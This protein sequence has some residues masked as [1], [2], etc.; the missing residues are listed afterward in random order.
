MAD[1]FPPLALHRCRFVDASPSPITAL[2]FPPFSLPSLKSKPSG[3]QPAPNRERALI[4]GTL[5]VGHANGN[6]DLFEWTGELGELQASQAWHRRKTLPG[7]YPSKVDSLTL[8]V[9]HPDTLP[10]DAVP[11]SSDLRLFSSGGGS[12]LLEWDMGR[13]SVR[14]T[15]SSQ[16][17][18][19]WSMAVN[20]ASTLLALGCEDGCVRLLSLLADTLQHFRRFDHVK[21]RILSI[22]WGPPVPQQSKPKV[23]SVRQPEESGDDSENEEDGWTDSWLVTG[24]SD[25]SLRKWD[26]STGRPTDRM[27][28]DKVKGDRTLVWT[29]GVLADGTVISGDSLGTVKFWD[30]LTCTQ[31]HSFPAHGA[32]VLCLTIGLDGT[33]V[34]TSGVDQKI[35]QFTHV[36]STPVSSSSTLATA[37]SRW[38]QSASRRMHSHDIRSLAIWPPYSPLPPA[39][40]RKPGSG[41]SVIAPILISGGLDMSVVITPCLPASVT[42]SAAAARVVNPLAK[43]AATTFEDSYYRRIPYFSA[44]SIARSARL[45]L[46]MHETG[47]NIW[48]VLEIPSTMVVIDGMNNSTDPELRVS[49]ESLLE[50]ELN[51]QTNLIASSLSDDGQ[52]LVVSDLHETKLF[53]LSKT[54]TGEIKPRRVRSL[55]AML[56][57]HICTKGCRSTGGSYF[58]FTPD[59]SKMIMASA[60]TSFILIIDLGTEEPTVL[61]RFDQHREL[62]SLHGGRLLRGSSRN[63]VRHA[64]D[65]DNELSPPDSPPSVIRMAISPDGQWLATSDELCR[66][67]VFNLDSIQYHTTLPSLPHPPNVLTFTPEKPQ[68]LMMVLPNNTIHIFDVERSEVPEWAHD[69]NS[70]IPKQLFNTPDPVL[71]VI[72]EP[73][74]SVP[75]PGLVNGDH[76]MTDATQASPG[77]RSTALSQKEA[78]FWGSSWL[79]KLR[80]DW[81]G[82]YT[83]PRKRRK[84]EARHLPQ[85][86]HDVPALASRP[87]LQNSAYDARNLRMVTHYR[88]IL[89]LD[90]VG[91]GE[92]VLVERPL[93]DVLSKLPPAFFKPKYGQT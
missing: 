75:P 63:Q 42:A 48:H 80:L 25:S 20:P 36:S 39:Y 32:D 8:T 89:A 84:S 40:R 71:G 43:N 64:D 65:D 23:N 58:V 70:R 3:K 47:L 38:I 91:Q 28:T 46:Y 57:A 66:T 87:D 81:M 55:T 93:V 68:I 12:E 52:W 14:R 77:L 44:V 74:P 78:I 26:I 15:V 79:C 54:P 27:V 37:T 1:L 7:P 9:R 73:G 21:C 83:E 88:P 41:A 2:A 60:L 19:I 17:G 35:V 11:S 59:S 6:I 33:T 69:L 22:A 61:R 67:L 45:V 51:V 34:F 24:G 82:K 10:S 18:S 72:F 50:M 56:E 53:V 30:P 29:V 90:F 49:W 86:H 5:V 92:L 31:T 76:D 4:F 85:D 62:I 13:S 16:G